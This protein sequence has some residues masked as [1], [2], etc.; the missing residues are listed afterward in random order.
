MAG[1]TMRV[2]QGLINCSQWERDSQT[3]EIRTKDYMSSQWRESNLEENCWS[4]FDYKYMSQV[5]TPES[6]SLFSWSK[7]GLENRDGGDSTLWMGTRGCQTPCHQDSY[8]CNLVCQVAGSKTWTLFSPEDGQ[9]LSPSR[10]PYE[11]SSVYSRLNM[12]SM[13]DNPQELLDK[14][15][16]A[17]PFTVTLEPGDVLYV[18]HGW[19][20]HVVTRS[21]WSVSVNTWVPLPQ[22]DR[23]RLA[24]ALVRL[25]V[26]NTVSR[27]DTSLQHQIL[28]PNEDDLL[29]TS[30]EEL[31]A[32]VQTAADIVKSKKPTEFER[33]QFTDPAEHLQPTTLR[34]PASSC[35]SKDN[36]LYRNPIVRVLNSLTDQSVIEKAVDN[37]LNDSL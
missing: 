7:F 37:I 13:A 27:L 8:G 1:S 6:L 35:V 32:M 3:R 24:E 10:V 34:I 12:T 21:P 18:P 30:I 22:D 15:R 36:D 23:S 26:A 16:Q 11:E 17:T 14:L 5:L 33:I 31:A 4:Y 19:W 9:Y 28:N 2:R 29:D 20:H 25:Q